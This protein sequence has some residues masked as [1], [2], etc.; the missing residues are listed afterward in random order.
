[1]GS[2]CGNCSKNQINENT[3]DLITRENLLLD[4]LII[5]ESKCSKLKYLNDFQNK[6]NILRFFQLTD[7]LNLLNTFRPDC[8]NDNSS[9]SLKFSDTM[10]NKDDWMRFV[11]T[12]II[13]SPLIPDIDPSFKTLQGQF[14][15]DVFDNL[16]RSYKFFYGSEHNF[17]PKI[18]TISFAFN[19][20]ARKISQKIEI[21][22]NLFA[23]FNGKFSL[24]DDVYTFLY[25]LI[26]FAFDFP[27]EFLNK[28]QDAENNKK[29]YGIDKISDMGNYLSVEKRDAI[30]KA[31]F[32]RET[33]NI[34]G[35][36]EKKTYDKNEFK[37]L[38]VN[39]ENG[40]AWIIDNGILRTKMEKS[41][42]D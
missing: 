37:N 14:Y 32:Q 33:K 16:L 25:S 29:Y 4:S 41:L 19:L 24:T 20:C 12:K 35:E 7:F 17:I 30:V 9:H 31:F 6:F 22:F 42:S 5:P 38:I 3:Y 23:D 11:N 2:F 34:F 26:F 15:D 18:M 28:Y 27:T 21:I 13:N 39:T 1:M 8:G 36:D 10:I 40:A